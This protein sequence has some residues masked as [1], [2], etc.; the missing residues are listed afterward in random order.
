MEA[1]ICADGVVWG[2]KIEWEYVVGLEIRRMFTII[3]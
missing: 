1:Q 2:N 3:V